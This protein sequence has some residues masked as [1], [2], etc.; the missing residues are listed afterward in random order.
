M[1]VWPSNAHPPLRDSA[2][3][4]ASI[5]SSAQVFRYK[6]AAGSD[7]AKL[8]VEYD[9]TWSTFRHMVCIYHTLQVGKIGFPKGHCLPYGEAK[10]FQRGYCLRSFSHG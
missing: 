7:A 8:Q 5:M 3:F 1:C 10:A 4:S 2:C 9:L 6:G